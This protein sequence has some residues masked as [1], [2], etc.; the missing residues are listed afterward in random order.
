MTGVRF[1]FAYPDAADL[2]TFDR[3]IADK[4]VVQQVVPD[5]VVIEAPTTPLMPT[6]VRLSRLTKRWPRVPFCWMVDSVANIDW[7]TVLKGFPDLQ[8][9]LRNPTHEQFEA[10]LDLLPDYGER[11]DHVVAKFHNCTWQYYVAHAKRHDMRLSLYADAAK[12]DPLDWEHRFD[13]W[14]FTARALNRY[15][16]EFTHERTG[17][18]FRLFH[19]NDDGYYEHELIVLPDCTASFCW[20][21]A[22]ENGKP[23]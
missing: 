7:E 1:V 19:H 8:L 22:L 16:W 13:A 15:C 10:W 2:P 20:W 21:D 6:L 23:Y 14:G 11:V 3:F 17:Y 18:A 12:P 4:F 5:Y 9:A